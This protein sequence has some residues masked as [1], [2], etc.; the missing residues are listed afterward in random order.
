MDL[1]IQ[2]KKG[3]PVLVTRRVGVDG[4]GDPTNAV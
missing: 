4:P 1:S 3:M 2:S